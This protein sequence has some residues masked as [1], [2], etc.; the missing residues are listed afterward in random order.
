MITVCAFRLAGLTLCGNSA[1]W[2]S[3]SRSATGFVR[4]PVRVTGRYRYAP[5]DRRADTYTSALIR[6]EK[7]RRAH[8]ETESAGVDI[9]GDPAGSTERDRAG[10]ALSGANAGCWKGRGRAAAAVRRSSILC[11][12]DAAWGRAVQGDH[13]HRPQPPRARHISPR[14]SRDGRHVADRGLGQRRVHARRQPI[15]NL[16][17][18]DR[19]PRLPGD[20]RRPARGS[21]ARSWTA[22]EP[23]GAPRRRST[24]AASHP[25]GPELR[26]RPSIHGRSH[27][28]GHRLGG[29]AEYAGLE[30][31]P[32]TARHVEDC[33]R[34]SVLRRRAVD[35]AGLGPPGD[36]RGDIQ[37][38]HKA[39]GSRG[40]QSS[41]SG[42]FK[43]AARRG[44]H[45]DSVHHR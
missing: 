2:L 27:A 14:Q 10:A 9:A 41:G 6:F 38:R 16:P 5:P 44:S 3:S 42:C 4:R 19:E 20:I 39:V 33:R 22:G 11:A 12:R 26:A 30:Q 24:T 35:A 31:I 7:R 29:R 8:G 37:Q 15:P 13:G 34:W 18:R 23:G 43:E 21:R 28:A 32:R 1:V 40:C 45:A 36:H 17:Y 25:R